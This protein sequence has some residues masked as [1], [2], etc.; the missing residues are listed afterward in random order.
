MRE[1]E[2]IPEV[3]PPEETGELTTIDVEHRLE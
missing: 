3:S 1:L 2:V